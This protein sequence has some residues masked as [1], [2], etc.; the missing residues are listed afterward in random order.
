MKFYE[1]LQNTINNIPINDKLIIFGDLNARTGYNVVPGIKQ[2][3]HE[4]VDNDNFCA[5]NKSS[6]TQ[7]NIDNNNNNKKIEVLCLQKY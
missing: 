5:Q 3:F 6:R 2:R 4:L 1:T 7:I